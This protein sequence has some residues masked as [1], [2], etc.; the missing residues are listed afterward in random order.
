MSEQLDQIAA[1]RDHIRTQSALR[2]ALGLI[3]GSGLGPLADEVDVEAAI[4]YADIPGFPVSTVPGHAGR[5]L[6]GRLAGKAVAVMQGRFHY[7]EGYP[8]HQIALPIRTLWSLGVETLVVTNAA[9]GLNPD[10][11]PAD[12]MLIT[13]HI[14]LMGANPLI[15]PNDEAIGP[16][17]PDMTLAYTATLRA[18]AIRVARE[19]GIP[20]HQ[21]VYV[22]MSGPSFETPAER[23]MLRLLGGDAVGM[24]TVPEAIAASH[25]GMQLLAFSAIANVATG[26]PEQP[27]DSHEEVLATVERAGVRLVRLLRRVVSAM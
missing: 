17:F 10:F 18:L 26:G 25:A 4:S 20:L 9:G 22:A 6:L 23:R 8:L 2:P 15:G 3:L 5:L 13:D 14:N 21:G 24:S 16:R 12:L 19:E 7:Y 27:P 1:A 11:A